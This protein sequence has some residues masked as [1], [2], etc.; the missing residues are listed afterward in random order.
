MHLGLTLWEAVLI[1]ALQGI[2]EWLPVSSSGQV[3]LLLT[4]LLG[5]NPAMSYRLSVT[6]HIGTAASGAILVKDELLDALRLGPWLRVALVPLLAGAPVALAIE[7]VV[8]GLSGDIFNLLIAIL[9][10]ITGLVTARA[11]RSSHFAWRPATSLSTLDLA[12]IGL[13][14]GL[15]ALPGLSR[16]AVTIAGLLLLRVPPDDAVRASI[17]MGAAA[18]GAMGLYEALQAQALPHSLLAAA[19]ASSLLAGALSAAAMLRIADKYKHEIAVFT[20]IIAVL[21]ALSALPAVLP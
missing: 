16:S 21:A 17:L 3:S 15:A 10:V 20:I 7:R 13:L 9:L 12:I 11:G 6:T 18:T 14:Q 8:T 5:L 19:L 2:L 1:G 4:S